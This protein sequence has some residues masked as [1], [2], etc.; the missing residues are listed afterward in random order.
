MRLP[1]LPGTVRLTAM[2]MANV[3]QQ[4]AFREKCPD[5]HEDEL[6]LEWLKTGDA[7]RLPKEDYQRVRKR[8]ARHRWDELTGELYMTT[9]NGKELL[10]P[11]PGD[12]LGL[13]REYHERAVHW[14]IRRT[15]NL[16][17]QRHY[18]EEKTLAEDLLQ[19]A[20][21]VKK[22]MMHA[23]CSLEI[24]Q[25]HDALLYEHRRSGGFEPKPHQFKNAIFK[26]KTIFRACSTE[27]RE[28]A[29]HATGALVIYDL[30]KQAGFL[31]KV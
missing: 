3:T 14:G 13:V 26:M 28:E 11:K 5:I 23:G 16:L 22:L 10:V 17:W 2:M 7:T 6:C 30:M 24:A 12:R 25:H 29:W 20:T 31:P 9:I 4:E 27:K 18:W 15:L 1:R 19:R 8:T 21:I